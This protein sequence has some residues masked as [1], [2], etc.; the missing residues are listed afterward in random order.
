MNEVAWQLRHLA[1]EGRFEVLIAEDNEAT[2]AIL[3]ALVTDAAPDAHV[4]IA[5]DGR[6]ALDLVRRSMPDLVV[7]DLHMPRLDGV[8]VCTALRSMGVAGKCMVVATSGHARRHEIETLR[9]QGFTRFLN[10]G[11]ELAA[12][13]PGL[14]EEARRRS[15][16]SAP[17][18]AS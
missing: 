8:G 2:A 9:R 11:Y 1:P 6:T 17:P 3:S 4:Q 10:K 18:C 13:M 14:I 16:R 7:V 15:M 5:P 12:N